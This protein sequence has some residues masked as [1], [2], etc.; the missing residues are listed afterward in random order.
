MD[1]ARS[2]KVAV[3]GEL[4]VVLCDGGL[5][6]LAGNEVARELL[7]TLAPGDDVADAGW[8]PVDGWPAIRELAAGG[9]TR[10]AIGQ[11]EY[12]VVLQTLGD[13]SACLL[14]EPLLLSSDAELS[15][16]IAWLDAMDE[17]ILLVDDGG[18]VVFANPRAER[19]HGY[20]TGSMVGLHLSS[21]QEPR[22][23]GAGLPED[24]G[25]FVRSIRGIMAQGAPRRYQLWHLRRDGSRYPATVL[26]RARRVGQRELLLVLVRDEVSEQ[27]RI[28]QLQRSLGEIQGINRAKSRV[29]STA[30]H[31]LRTPLTA[32]LGF[33]DLLL[34]DYADRASEPGRSLDRIR[35]SAHILDRQFTRMIEFF[36]L[37]D[38]RL[39][40]DREP[41]QPASVIRAACDRWREQAEGKGLT[42]RQRIDDS[43]DRL[44]VSADPRRLDAALDELVDNAIRATG[45]GTIEIA[46]SRAGDLVRFEVLDE[47]VGLAVGEREH[48]FNAF[49][50]QGELRHRG[51]FGIGIGLHVVRKLAELMGGSAELVATTSRG[52]TFALSLPVA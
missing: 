33:C 11:R 16:A 25:E 12:Q 19:D 21:L 22:R 32:I 14:V 7:G 49:T 5:R 38:G 2:S 50:E 15:Q 47:G 36:K 43:V 40:L 6:Y 46:A 35:S 26:L 3:V 4:G 18:V 45:K 29:V 44:A 8:R 30:G 10:M 37:E 9:I 13:G 17:A 48:L 1:V 42:L 31:D 41:L 34:L 23:P 28:D 51:G 39:E 52:S 24:R 20:D 27:G